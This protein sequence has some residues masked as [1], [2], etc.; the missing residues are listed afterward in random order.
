MRIEVADD[1]EDLLH[2]LRRQPHR[3][4]VKQDHLRPRHQRAADGAHL[5]LAAGDVAGGRAAAL[6][7]PRKIGVDEIE[8]AAHRRAG[9]AAREGAGQQ[10]LLDREMREAM[11]ALHDLDAAAPHQLVRR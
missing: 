9:A 7:E 10:V 2:E 6:L 3:G 1:L 5:L 8:I 11:A 4:L